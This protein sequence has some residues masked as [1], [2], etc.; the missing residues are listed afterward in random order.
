ML[1]FKKIGNT[2]RIDPVIP[3]HWEGFE[4]RYQFGASS[5]QI[6]VSNPRHLARSVQVVKMDGK[7]L[8]NKVIPLVDD[9]QQHFIEVIL[10]D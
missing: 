7:M 8:E 5:Y 2:L 1:G 9:A 6:T 4:I 3:P 10:G